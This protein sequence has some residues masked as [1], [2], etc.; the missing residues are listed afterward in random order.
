M[1]PSHHLMHHLQ[2][3]VDSIHLSRFEECAA[4]PLHSVLAYRGHNSPVRSGFRHQVA[5]PYCC[6]LSRLDSTRLLGL[7]RSRL[8]RRHLPIVRTSRSS[9]R[10]CLPQFQSGFDWQVFHLLL[11]YCRHCWRGSQIEHEIVSLDFLVSSRIS[12]LAGLSLAILLS[13]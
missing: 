5:P 4:A 12:G 3:D 13:P 10:R 6:P 2:M 8:Y 11:K 7:S 1:G 9:S